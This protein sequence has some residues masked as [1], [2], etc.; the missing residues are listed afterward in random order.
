MSLYFLAAYRSMVARI[1]HDER[2][3]TAIEYGLVLALI[4]VVIVVAVAT[5]LGPA[6]TSIIN[7]ITTKL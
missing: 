3:Q 6:V 1:A 5:G 4:A 7:K 2:G